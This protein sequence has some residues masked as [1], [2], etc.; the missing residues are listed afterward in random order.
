MT[1][2]STDGSTSTGTFRVEVGDEN[3]FEIGP[4]EDIDNTLN[5][6]AENGTGGEVVGITAF[7][8][9]LDATDT[10]T[11]STDDPRFDID[12]D[13][14][15]LTVKDGVS[16]DFETEP[17]TDVVITATSTDGSSSTGT[18]TV[19]I[20][21]VNE[22]PDLDFD[23]TLGPGTSVTMT[24]VEESAGYSNVLGVF[25]MDVNGN[26]IGGEIVWVD[27]NTLTPGDSETTYLEGVEAAEIGYFLI[28]DGADL[29][30]GLIGGDKI[31]FQKDANGHWQAV[32]ADGTPL[33]GQGANVFFSGDGS[34]NPDGFDHTTETGVIIGFEDLVNGGDKDFD[35]P[36]FSEATFET[37]ADAAVYEE[38]LGA[39]VGALSVADPDAGDTHTFTVSDDRFEV[40]S[41]GSGYVLKLKDD[42]ALDYET[43]TEVTVDVTVTDSGGLSDT[44]TITIAVIDVNENT[45]PVGPVTDE[46]AASNVVQENSDGGTVVGVTAFA[47]DPD[48][49]DSVTYSMDDPR[50]EIDPISGVVTVA[51]GAVID[52]ETTPF[53]DVEVTATSSDGSTSQGTF[54]ITVGDENEFDI[55]PVTD[56]DDTGNF[57]QENAGEGTVVGVTAFATDPDA[58]DTVTYSITDPRFEIDPDTGVITVA[59][60]AVIDREATPFIDV[61]VTA[62]STDGSTSKGTFRI[63]I[64]DENEFSIGPVT[65]VDTAANFVE[66]NSDGGTVVG[67]TAFATDP[68]ATDSVTYSITDPR[69]NIDPDTGVITVADGAVI[70]YETKPFIDIE[71]TATSTDGSTSTGTFRIEVGDDADEFD[72]G[73]VT[74][75]DNTLNA[76]AENGTGGEVVGITAF[77]EDLDPAD[78]VTYSTDDPRFDID[79]DTGVLTVKDGVSFDFETEPTTDVV[80]TATSSDGSSSTGTFTVNILDVNEAPDLVFHTGHRSRRDGDVDLHI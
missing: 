58:T 67:V 18:F 80:I 2:T 74:D 77:A 27:Q 29:N 52:R 40:V 54:R 68:D 24:F 4:I 57:V 34:L 70:D 15:V 43:E 28:P 64:G 36:R 75:I 38:E 39:E 11:Y 13:T 51:D 10:V 56:V 55:G 76:V 25:Y 65:D 9:D 35:D 5:A 33:V 12:P 26:P 8:E 62:T 7:A 49:A 16:F 53:I 44:E 23:P 48:A 41:T 78:T 17:T 63:E 45:A 46:D 47:R 14:G 21:D 3:E 59:D 61:E 42:Q 22:A 1:A 60:G 69:F 72:I 19:N 73:P 79:P 6:V 71:V 31:T 20:L 66:E 32:S 37:N 30:S 50:F